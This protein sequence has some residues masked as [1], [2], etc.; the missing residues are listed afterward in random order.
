M[1]ELIITCNGKS[2]GFP[3]YVNEYNI[4]DLG[5][6][7][8]REVSQFVQNFLAPECI[9]SWIYEGGMVKGGVEPD[10]D[11]TSPAFSYVVLLNGK[12]CNAAEMYSYCETVNI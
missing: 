12:E 2:K 6:Q 3:L 9:C 7:A 4:P 8:G 10:E 1:L 11:W 5:G